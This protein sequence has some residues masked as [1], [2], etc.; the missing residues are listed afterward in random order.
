MSKQLELLNGDEFYD[1]RAEMQSIAAGFAQDETEAY[2]NPHD[3]TP[4]ASGGWEPNPIAT[5]KAREHYAKVTGASRFGEAEETFLPSYEIESPQGAINPAS[6]AHMAEN[7]SGLDVPNI[8]AYQFADTTMVMNG[9]H[10]VN[11]ALARGQML[12]PAT[13]RRAL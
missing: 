9:N 2:P 10:R 4:G 3:H 13:L 8:S 5:P 1:P 6:V 11:A 7:A 12:I